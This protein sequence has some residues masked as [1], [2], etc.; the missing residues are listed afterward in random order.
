[1]SEQVTSKKS[2]KKEDRTNIILYT[3]I[4]Y[5]TTWSILFP[6]VFFYSTLDF[7]LQELWHSLGAIGPAVAGIV[8]LTRKSEEKG[9]SWLK[10]GIIKIPE[11]KLVIFAFIP[12]IIFVVSL[13]LEIVLGLTDVL[14]ILRENNV[15]DLTSLF[16]FFLPSLSYGFFEEIGWRGYLLPKLQNY[17]T[18]LKATLF[19]TFIWYF[20]HLPMFFYRFDLFFA[21]MFMLPL[22][23]S[24][25]IVFTYL[26]NASKGSILIVIIFHIS[27]D[28]TSSSGFSFIAV[29]AVSAFFIMMD[30]RAIKM[31]GI[32]SLAQTEKIII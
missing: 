32:E 7:Y 28:I 9:V 21:I 29:I 10:K 27:Y 4:A 24:G 25:S 13:L 12:L 3:L 23:I 31:F 8:I 17:Y 11:V 26:Y 16:F 22:L 18:A 19:L 1:M 15:I 6:L 2:I 5:G 30:I 14:K 20:W